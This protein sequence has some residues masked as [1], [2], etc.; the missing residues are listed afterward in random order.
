MTLE[1]KEEGR[2]LGKGRTRKQWKDRQEKVRESVRSRDVNERGEY[3][4]RKKNCRQAL[5]FFALN[6]P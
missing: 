3:K 4:W 2:R 5:F 6:T 1:T